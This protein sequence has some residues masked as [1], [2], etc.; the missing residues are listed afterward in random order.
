MRK[1][2]YQP[3]RAARRS[4]GSC[5]IDICELVEAVE[6]RRLISRKLDD[7]E[8]LSVCGGEID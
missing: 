2:G 4:L 7:L 5:G 1:D 8:R 3:M 6:I